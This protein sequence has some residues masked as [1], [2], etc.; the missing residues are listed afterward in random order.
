[1]F[2][3]FGG[4]I[5]SLAEVATK[6]LAAALISADPIRPHNIDERNTAALSIPT[7]I[8]LG[9]G[10][11]GLYERALLSLPTCSWAE[12]SGVYENLD[13]RI[14]PFAQAIPPLEDTRATGRIFWDLLALP[15]AYSA[16]HARTLMAES[17]LA[18][19][20]SIAQPVGRVKVEEME[21][22][23]L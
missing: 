7:I 2:A 13:G 10:P 3:H 22:A 4:N 5:C 14:Q 11:A 9:L 19:Y 18:E 20:A 16:P 17:G 23:P 8:R 1:M 12:K 15:G 6:K 21:F